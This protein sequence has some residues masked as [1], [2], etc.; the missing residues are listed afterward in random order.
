[1]SVSLKKGQRV[2]LTKGNAGLNNL[3]IGL[4]WD[5][6]EQAKAKGG[7]LGGLFGGAKPASVD[8]DSSVIMLK[9]DRL[10]DKNDVVFFGNLTVLNGAVKHTGDNLTGEGDGDDEQIL[11][12]LNSIPADYNRLVFVVNIYDAVKR[13]QH[14]GMI[15]NAYIRIVDQATNKELLKYNLSDDYVNQKTLVA[16]E[17]YRNGNEWKFAALGNG[18]ADGSLSEIIQKYN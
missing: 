12:K 13:N 9:E 5:P 7:L 18:T 1:M 3:L 14:F 4:G 11:I 16:G 17:I 8:C 2:D 15:K 10:R 6:A